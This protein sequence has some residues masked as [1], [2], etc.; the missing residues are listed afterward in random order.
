MLLNPRLTRINEHKRIKEELLLEAECYIV[1]WVTGG[2]GVL[3]IGC[4]EFELLANR[5]FYIVP[6]QRISFVR[7]PQTGY[8]LHFSQE[9]LLGSTENKGKNIV[10]EWLLTPQLFFDLNDI[11]LLDFKSLWE[12]LERN[13]KQE[14]LDFLIAKLINLIWVYPQAIQMRSRDS[15]SLKEEWDLMKELKRT[16]ELNYKE[17]KDSGFYARELGIPLWRL[18][19]IAKQVLGASVHDIVLTR[20]LLE[21]KRL[22][23]TTKYSIKEINFELGFKD[24]SYFNKVF[25][26]HCGIT[27]SAYRG[28]G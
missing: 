15:G 4:E 1:L 13:W 19:K 24:P 9:F 12:I 3:K 16:V 8:V 10:L 11:Q 27:P 6:G 20:T 5:V 23:T 25:K 18:N 21:A 17:H 28:A 7:L 14:S 26:R 2:K 22:L